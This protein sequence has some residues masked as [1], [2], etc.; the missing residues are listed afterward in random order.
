MARHWG[1]GDSR[2]VDIRA[3]VGTRAAERNSVEEA[4]VDNSVAVEADTLA[5]VDMQAAVEADTLVEEHIREAAEA[6][7][8]TQEERRQQSAHIRRVRLRVVALVP[9]VLA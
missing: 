6:V 9:L 2:L 8:N 1:Y 4:A 3:A 7:H 5:V